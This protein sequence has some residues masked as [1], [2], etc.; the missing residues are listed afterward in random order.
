MGQEQRCPA[1]LPAWLG[2]H[3]LS[4]DTLWSGPASLP[5]SAGRGETG[6]KPWGVE[7]VPRGLSPAWDPGPGG[8]WVGRAPRPACPRGTP[9]EDLSSTTEQEMSFKR[10]LLSNL[11]G[12]SH[13][14]L[15]WT[16]VSWGPGASLVTTTFAA[17]G[18]VRMGSPLRL[19]GLIGLPWPRTA[20]PA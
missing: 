4:P 2:G 7:P 9:P 17:G 13:V 12:R 6:L 10:W 11:D 5:Q 3:P 20:P 18:G 14:L 1:S 15:T 19:P 16:P 8:W